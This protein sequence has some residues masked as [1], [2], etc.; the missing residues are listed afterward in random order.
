MANREQK[1]AKKH[2]ELHQ[3][4]MNDKLNIPGCFPYKIVYFLRLKRESY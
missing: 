3:K 2:P 4:K 1:E